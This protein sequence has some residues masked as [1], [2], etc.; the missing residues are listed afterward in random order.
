[1]ALV[2]L[3]MLVLTVSEVMGLHMVDTVE[4]AAEIP[5]KQPVFFEKHTQAQ[6]RISQISGVIP[7][8]HPRALYRFEPYGDFL[9]PRRATTSHHSLVRKAK[10][11]KKKSRSPKIS[12]KASRIG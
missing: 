11:I 10:D 8:A 2:H 7:A 1:M 12:N 6:V 9:K 5:K 4:A 3:T